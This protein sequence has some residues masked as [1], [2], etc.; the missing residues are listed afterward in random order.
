MKNILEYQKEYWHK[1]S[2]INESFNSSIIRQIRDQINDII[3][4]NHEYNAENKYGTWRH[5]TNKKFKELFGRDSGIQ[6]DKIKDEDFKEY[7]KSDDEGIKLVKRCTSNRSNSFSALII[8]ENDKG[9]PKLSGLIFASF[10]NNTYYS[11]ISNYSFK[12][13]SFRTSDAQSYLTNKYYILDLNDF[14][15]YQIRD[16]RRTDRSGA[17]NAFNNDELRDD[18]YKQIAS[19]NL[20]RY[21]AYAAKI[22]AEKDANDGIS[23]KV[24]EYSKKIMDI[25][26]KISKDPVKYVKYEYNIATLI[27]LLRDEKRYV[28]GKNPYWAGTNGLLTLYKRYMKSKLSL[29]KGSSYSYE[30]DEYTAAKKEIEKMFKIIDEKLEKFADVA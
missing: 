20:E 5:P 29:S 11:L 14:K 18:E 17:I 19:R 30:R 23:E 6:W 13:D 25:T 24:E 4:L 16:K 28:Q 26:I 3:E 9:D 2:F 12:S 10:G 1:Q 27:D 15:T 8:L 7:S 22:K 21:K